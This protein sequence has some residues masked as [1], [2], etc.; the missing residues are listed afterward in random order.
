M[1][2]LTHDGRVTIDTSL[3]N[4]GLRKGIA[5]TNK[6]MN[7]LTQSLRTFGK[8]AVAAFSIV[9]IRSFYNETPKVYYAVFLKL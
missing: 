3:D 1:K 4:T 2:A 8:A 7:G 9:A 5:S 6:E